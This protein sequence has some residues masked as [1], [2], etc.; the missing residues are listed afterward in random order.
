MVCWSQTL[1]R[2]INIIMSRS[3]DVTPV[4]E[5]AERQTN[6]RAIQFTHRSIDTHTC[7]PAI[8]FPHAWAPP[9]SNSLHLHRGRCGGHPVSPVPGRAVGA[10]L[11]H[12]ECAGT[13]ARTCPR[14]LRRWSYLWQ[15][16]KN[17]WW[18]KYGCQYLYVLDFYTP[19]LSETTVIHHRWF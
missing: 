7:H 10:A 15:L 14:L 16:S 17:K 13:T 8:R 1:N 2:N 3:T 19:P 11:A 4:G 18:L 5:R 9:I 6:V 12:R